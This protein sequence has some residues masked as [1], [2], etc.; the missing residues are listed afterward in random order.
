M[1]FGFIGRFSKKLKTNVSAKWWWFEKKSKF[2]KLQVSYTFK[3]NFVILLLFFWNKTLP[4]THKYWF[5][6]YRLKLGLKTKKEQICNA[7]LTN[8]EKGEGIVHKMLSFILTVYVGLYLNIV[9]SISNIHYLSRRKE[10]I[11]A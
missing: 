11:K 6:K 10:K 1:I 8:Q 9:E 4:Q 2:L 7:S 5:T 3:S